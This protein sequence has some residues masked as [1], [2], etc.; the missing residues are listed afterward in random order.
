MAFSL[1]SSL[2][3]NQEKEAKI[4][5]QD[6]MRARRPELYSD[7]VLNSEAIMD[8]SQFEYHLDT[9]TNRKQEIEFETFARLLAEKEICPNLLPQTGPTGGGD[10]KVDTET[11]PV[12]DEIADRWYE[13][14]GRRGA[15]ERWAFAISAKK[16]WVP[17]VKS[18]VKKIIKTGRP[19]TL[20]YFITNQFAPDKKRSEVEDSLRELYGMDIRILDRTWIVEKMKTNKRWDIAEQAL[21]LKITYSQHQQLLGPLDTE[22]ARELEELEAKI[23]DVAHYKNAPYQLAEECLQTAL[24]ARGLELPRSEIDG[25]FTRALRFARAHKDSRQT[26]RILYHQALTAIWWFNDLVE[27]DRIYDEIAPHIITGES[28]WEFEDLVNL[29][30]TLICGH[31]QRNGMIEPDQWDVRDF[32]LR[33]GLQEHVNDISKLTSSLWARTQLLFMQAADAVKLR[34][35]PIIFKELCSI[36]ESARNRLEYPFEPVIRFVRDLGSIITDDEAFDKLLEMVI[37]LQ[38]ERLGEIEEGRMRLERGEQKLAAKKYYEAIDQCAKAQ[39]LLGKEE[40]RDEFITALAFTSMGYEAAGLLWAARAN[41]IFAVDCCIN[42]YSKGGQIDKRAFPLLR[43]LIW[44]EIQLGRVPY[45]LCWMDFLG[46]VSTVLELSESQIEKLHEEIQAI[47]QVLGILILRT[48]HDD[49]LSLNRIVGILEEKSLWASSF[50]ALFMLGQ[51]DV[52]RADTKTANLAN[53]D[54]FC[55]NWLAHPAAADLPDVA[56]WHIEATSSIQTAL[57]GCK[58]VVTSRG[59]GTTV[60]LAES[61]LAFLEAFFS[62]AL[63]LKKIFS[64]RAELIIE[65]RQS[66]QAKFPFAMRT[67]ENDCGETRIIITHP[68]SAIT[69]LIDDPGYMERMFEFFAIVVTEMQVVQMAK[70]LE[71]LFAKHRAQDRAYIVSTSPKALTSLLSDRPKYRASDWTETSTKESY[72]RTRTTSWV[73]TTQAA[74]T[75]TETGKGDPIKIEHGDGEDLFGIDGLKHRD[76]GNVSPLN[77]PLWD[78]AGWQGAG[79]ITQPSGFNPPRMLLIFSN[80]DAGGK[81]FRGW[82]KRVGNTDSSGWISLTIVTGIDRN[83]P[84]HYRVIVGSDDNYFKKSAE[85]SQMVLTGYRMLDMMPSNNTNLNRFL[86]EYRRLNRFIIQPGCATQS[87]M[88]HATQYRE[89][90]RNFLGGEQFEGLGIELAKLKVIPAWKVSRNDLIASAM[91]GILDP[92][93]PV[94]VENAPIREVIAMF[95]IH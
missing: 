47:D 40:H 54:D 42:K 90:E 1:M 24:L 41:L 83:H 2:K 78:K 77:L 7:S 49:W 3:M 10:S 35:P 59:G 34:R 85:N 29:R 50:A 46:L 82:K 57:L 72:L 26:R 30:T 93:I 15:N 69:K 17:K 95:D 14:T 67:G 12:A 32:A 60:L 45:V 48:K 56:E 20:I 22:R 6:F 39:S 44:L 21:G 28:V 13:G 36:L 64:P 51:E 94:G 89:A 84:D 11:Y 80:G 58:V 16:D 5:N 91:K 66:E 52:I 92:L 73:P 76:L 9:L 27:A 55:S 38:K 71:P 37:T 79:Y 53:L 88:Q 87:E 62:T 19:Y 25:R 4:S 75:E 70:E 33:A 74:K 61:M 65:I 81:I 68:P 31:V 23:K 86:A 63:Q 18:D 8:Y 43:R